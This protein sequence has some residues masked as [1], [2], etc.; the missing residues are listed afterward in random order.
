MG[1]TRRLSKFLGLVKLPFILCLSHAIF[2]TSIERPKSRC[3]SCCQ[4]QSHNRDFEP[5][6]IKILDLTA[7]VHVLYSSMRMK[8]VFGA[9]WRSLLW[10]LFLEVLC[11]YPSDYVAVEFISRERE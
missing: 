10:G 1:H 4:K 6:E 3:I 5:P 7:S 2:G 8:R 9:T 11:M